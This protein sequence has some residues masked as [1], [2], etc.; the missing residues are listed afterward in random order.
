MKYEIKKEK[1][2]LFRP[3]SKSKQ[4][5]SYVSDVALSDDSKPKRF[6]LTTFLR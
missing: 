4:K 3:N 1:R 6:L 5:F 2:I